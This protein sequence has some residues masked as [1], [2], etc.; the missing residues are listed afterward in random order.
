MRRWPR[1]LFRATS[2]LAG[3]MLFGG[4]SRAQAQASALETELVLRTMQEELQRTRTELKRPGRPPPYYVGFW[5]VDLDV[6]ELRGSLGAL[7]VD[8]QDSGRRIK[9]D[10]RVGDPLTDNSN[11][12]G[13]DAEFGVRSPGGDL[14]PAVQAAGTPLRRDFWLLSDQ[15][16]RSANELL[17][18]KLAQR[19]SEVEVDERAPDFSVEAP[20]SVAVAGQFPLPDRQ[21]LRRVV[22]GASR[23]LLDF[24]EISDSEV[25]VEAWAVRRH[26]V[27]SEGVKSYEP[28]GLIRLSIRASTQAP[29]GMP[30]SQSE[31]WFGPLSAE[32][33]NL[34]ARRIGKELTE[35]RAAPLVDDYSGPVLFESI[36]A[37][38]IAAELLSLSLSGTPGPNEQDTPLAPRLGKRV[39]PN[40]FSL[41]DDP[42]LGSYKGLTL[43]GGYAFDDEGIPPQRVSLVHGGRL[44]QLL[45]SRTPRKE[46][47][48]SNGHARSGLSGW[49]RG[50]IGN[51]VMES[52]RGATE[53]ALRRRLQRAVAD[54]GLDYGLVATRLESRDFSTNGV[55]PPS[56]QRLY[57]LYADGR[58]ELVRGASFG[59]M[60]VGDLRDILGASAEVT[61]A[62]FATSWPSGLQTTSTVLAPSLLFEEIEVKRPKAAH[63]RPPALPKPVLE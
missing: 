37:P 27:S 51:L 50:G 40:D 28:A 31:E 4:S 25:S 2:L 48:Q 57:K 30:L 16:Y 10:L 58:M 22:L 62:H 24:P 13:S 18:Q 63:S 12:V 29:D 3:V 1:S 56:P 47:A 34:N 21:S 39:L 54:E 20:K 32:A 61:S 55:A 15:A 38:Q 52:S 45:M 17:D 9:V 60:S 11:F 35:L 8:R 5:V 6:I 33:A 26:F 42:T 7:S 14:E 41:F 44:K 43:L 59:E 36:A 49:A 46:F 23:Q 53:A 19:A